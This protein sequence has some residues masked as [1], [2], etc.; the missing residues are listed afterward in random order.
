MSKLIDFFDNGGVFLFNEDSSASERTFYQVEELMGKA[1]GENITPTEVDEYGIL[2][3]F[4]DC[5]VLDDE[6]ALAKY[7][8]DDYVESI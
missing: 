6:Q 3:I 4:Y 5:S 7:M 8:N 1:E 2:C